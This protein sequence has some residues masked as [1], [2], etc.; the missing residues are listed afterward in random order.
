MDDKLIKQFGKLFENHTTLLRKEIRESE[1]RVKSELNK[2][3]SK[4][5]EDTIGAI[6]DLMN[7]GYHAH[8]VRLKTVEKRLNIPHTQ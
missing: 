8:E 3:I 2:A 1:D 6:T 4:S 7:S 5:Q